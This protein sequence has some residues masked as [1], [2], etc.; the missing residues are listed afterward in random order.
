MA[1]LQSNN[2]TNFGYATYK[3]NHLGGTYY[4][5]DTSREYALLGQLCYRP[6]CMNYRPGVKVKYIIDTDTIS[7]I[8]DF[9]LFTELFKYYEAKILSTEPALVPEIVSGVHPEL[10]IGLGEPE[11]VP[12]GMWQRLDLK[13][14]Y[15]FAQF[16]FDDCGNILSTK[17]FNPNGSI[18]NNLQ[19]EARPKKKKYWP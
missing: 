13:R 1:F 11:V 14:K 18:L 9:T 7:N 6:S 16:N 3:N 2:D 10:N 4:L 19:Y 15:V 17:Y 5:I 12:T 8:F